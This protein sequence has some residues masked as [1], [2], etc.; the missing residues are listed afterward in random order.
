MNLPNGKEEGAL[1]LAWPS[2]QRE[3]IRTDTGREAAHCGN[4]ADAS[5]T[6]II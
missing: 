5:N 4:C 6:L 1:L 3:V 2:L